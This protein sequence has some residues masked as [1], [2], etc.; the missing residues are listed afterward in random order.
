MGESECGGR[1]GRNGGVR[2]ES[3]GEREM[4]ME[5]KERRRSY[6]T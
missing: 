6:P 5:E 3:E 2:E 4:E 1:R